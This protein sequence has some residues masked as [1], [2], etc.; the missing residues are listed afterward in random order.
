MRRSRFTEEQ[1]IA[2]LRE[3]ESFNGKLRDELLNETL[4][5][6]LADARAKLAA[7]RRH[8]NQVRPHSSLG[9][10]TPAEYAG[11][12]CGETGRRAANPDHLR[13]PASCQRRTPRLKSTQDSRYD[14]MNDGGQ[15]RR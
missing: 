4:F 14:W 1:I 10:R 3:Q 13:A 6:S 2:V 12:L 8:F 5:S 7:W 11:V 15:V 9:Y